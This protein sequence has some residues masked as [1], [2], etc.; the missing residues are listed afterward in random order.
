LSFKMALNLQSII[1]QK[2]WIDEI[3]L[4]H[5]YIV[6]KSWVSLLIG[7]LVFMGKVS[8]NDKPKDIWR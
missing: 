2:K 4:H 5:A 1:I 7:I 6:N 3:T 8:L